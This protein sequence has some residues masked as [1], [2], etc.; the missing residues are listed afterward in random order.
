[1][2]KKQMLLAGIVAGVTLFSVHAAVDQAKIDAVA[3]GELKEAKASYWGF[4]PQDSTKILQTAINSKVPRLIIDKQA[5]PWITGPLLGVSDQEIVF[6]DGAEL[7]AKRGLFKDRGDCLIRLDN[8]KNSAI[9]GLGK[10]GILRMH[11]KD[12][13][14]P[15]QYEK[16]E[17][18]HTVRYGISQ[19]IRI[20]NMKFL[21]SGGDGVYLYNVENVKVKNILCDENHRQGMSIISGKNI[22]VEDSVFTRTSGTSPQSGLDIEPNRPGEVLSNIVFRNCRFTDNVRWGILMAPAR[23]ESE[24][25]GEMTIRFE[26]CVAENNQEDEI[27]FFGNS[28][29]Q[30]DAPVQGKLE[31]INCKAISNRKYSYLWPAVEFGVDVGHEFEIVLKDMVIKRGGNREKALRFVFHYPF[32]RGA[33]PLSQIELDNVKF[34]DCSARDALKIVDYSFSGRTDNFTGAIEDK[35]GKKISVDAKLLQR[36]GA[37]AA[38]EFDFDYSDRAVQVDGPKDGAMEKYPEFPLFYEAT[39]WIFA[40]AGQQVA[41]SLKYLK[42]SIAQ[43]TGVYLTPPDG[44]RRRIGAL[45]PDEERTFRFTAGAAGI[46]KVS[47]KAT[48]LKVALTGANAPAGIML[49]PYDSYMGGNSGTLY[50]TIPDG[51]PEFGIRV[52]GSV[53]SRYSVNT[54]K[55]AVSDPRDRIVF[56]A[57]DVGDGVQYTGKAG[58][59]V[60]KISFA[61]KIGA[62]NLRMMGVCPYIG[63]RADRTPVLGPR[64]SASANRTGDTGMDLF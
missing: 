7:Q 10:G 32:T 36:A 15:K 35:D 59:G 20:E 2:R 22:L 64:G 5:S 40:K 37:K 11:K 44:E 60:W 54:V 53:F 41:F 61:H 58:S 49:R 18:R 13:Q 9:I 47:L 26:N 56:S 4:D 45:K 62:Y 52:W 63:L 34:V 51:A 25:A 55:T 31:F 16:S 42:W 14:D 39:F 8:V 29:F 38:P 27:R 48:A 50:F 46:Y 17:H 19:N 21:L 12:Y 30:T 43:G 24:S 23:F 6:E 28:F 3:K 57:D 33:K 1:M